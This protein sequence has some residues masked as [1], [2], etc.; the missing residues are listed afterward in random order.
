MTFDF[1]KAW[2]PYEHL[3]P[4]VDMLRVIEPPFA[5]AEEP[6]LSLFP[7]II[8]VADGPKVERIYFGTWSLACAVEV[9]G[10]RF[11]MI[12][13]AVKQIQ[14]GHG[15][16]EVPHGGGAPTTYETAFIQVHFDDAFWT[17]HYFGP[18]R[19]AWTATVRQTF[20]AGTLR[21]GR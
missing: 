14:W 16:A 19:A 11:H 10:R 17:I 4:T 13:R 9:E 18:D 5:Y 2:E 15:V 1:K 8:L 6:M 7:S 3:L 12:Q 20:P 21:M